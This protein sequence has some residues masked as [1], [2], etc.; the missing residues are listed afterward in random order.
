LL[1]QA[2]LMV[3]NLL[4]RAWLQP[5]RQQMPQQLQQA[6]V[7]RSSPVAAGTE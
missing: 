1:Y 6:G 2:D 3:A 4:Q 5:V 7:D